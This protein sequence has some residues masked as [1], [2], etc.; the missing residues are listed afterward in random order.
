MKVRGRL[1]VLAC[2]LAALLAL[3]ASAFGAP[4]QGPELTFGTIELEGSNGYEVEVASLREGRHAPIALVSAKQGPLEASYEVR[5]ELGTGIRATFGSLGQLDVGFERRRKD[6]TKP[7]PGCRW[8][9]ERGVFR[10]SFRFDG[11]GGY[12]S[13]EAVDPEG[14]V[15]R[16]PNGFCGFEDDRP[17]R[18]G[19]PGL[20]QTVLAARAKADGGILTFEASRWSIERSIDFS[21]SLRERVGEMRVLRTATVQ[22]TRRTFLS[23]K[24]SR[25]SVSPPQPFRGSARFRDPAGQPPT[26]TGSLAV[27]FPGAPD[28]ALAGDSFAAKLCPRIFI[29]ARCLRGR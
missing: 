22:G 27:S 29:L 18:R 12:T 19:I 10:G 5:A 3:P 1:A 17:A 4:V 11:E 21:A 23:P 28:V 14:R 25:A 9:S 20:Y 24:K 6:V 26:W 16:L 13:V 8:I 7:E 15:L 2:A